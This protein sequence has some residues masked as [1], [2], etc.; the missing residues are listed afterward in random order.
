MPDKSQVTHK[1]QKIQESSRTMFMWVAGMAA[2]VGFCGVVAWFV[3]QQA[4]FKIKVV[5]QKN[6]TVKTLRDN[7]A[8]IPDLKDNIRVLET[9][10]ALNLAKAND[11]QNALQVV[12]DAL[13]ADANALALGGSLQEHLVKDVPNLTLETLTVQPTSSSLTVSERNT[14]KKDKE[15]AN[16]I[17]FRLTVSSPDANA[18]KT[19]LDRFERSIRVIDIDSLSL[20]R[21]ER[22]YTMT[23]EAH[24]YYEPAKVIEL[25]EKVVK[26]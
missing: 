14:R 1:R 6:D 17:N 11:E 8:A 10:T 2:V 13:P 3:F 12:L 22:L 7:N 19:M 26:P 18:I 24:A 5:D 15:T 23:I 4:A 20:E 16:K 21:S 9:N 25:Q